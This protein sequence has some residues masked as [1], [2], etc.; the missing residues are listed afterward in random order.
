MS[1]RWSAMLYMGL[2][3][4]AYALT[5]VK[6][7]PAWRYFP[8]QHAWGWTGAFPEPSMA[9]FWKVGLALGAGLVGWLAGLGLERWRPQPP[10]WI[11]W[12][13]WALFTLAVCAAA[14]H[15]FVKW[16]LGKG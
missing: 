12:M 7:F 3:S 16:I 8:A 10:R 11:D 4:A 13:G 15:E 2:F 1:K 5:F 14:H 9:W 6:G